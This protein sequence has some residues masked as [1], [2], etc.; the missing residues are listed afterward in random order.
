VSAGYVPATPSRLVEQGLSSDNVRERRAEYGYNEVKEAP[1]RPL[2]EFLKRLW[3][4]VPWMLEVA[5]ALELVLGKLP[6]TLI[7]AGLLVFNAILGEVQELRAQ[8]ALD[9]LR[10]RLHVTARVRRDASWAS[11]PA[12]ELV[13]GDWIHVRMGDIVPADC[14]LGEGTVE[15]DQSALTGESTPVARSE[16]ETI[17]SGSTVRRGEASGTVTATGP[18]SFFGR[19][20]E[21]VRTAR[22][23]GHLE[24]LL[25]NIVR[26]LVTIDAVLAGTVLAAALI[27]GAPLL[28]LLPFVLVLLIA[29]VP[30]AMPATFT[31]A[32]AIEAR[33]LADEGVLVTGLSA[34]QEAATMEML[35]VDKTGTLTQN[36]AVLEGVRS[37]AGISDDELVAW[38]A[39]ACDESTQDPINLAILEAMR[40]RKMRAFPR[41]KFLPFDPANKRSEGEVLRD[42]HAYRVVLGS[43]LVVEKLARAP[44][45][46]PTAVDRLAGS[47]ARV[48]AVAVGV[49]DNLEVRGLVALA[50]PPREDAAALVQSL[51]ALGIRVIMLTGDTLP[52]ARAVA[53]EVG[54]GDHIGDRVAAT[55]DPQRYDG[56][57]GVYPE[58]KFDLVKTLQRSGEVV[59]MTGDGV[60]DA[61]ALKQAEVGIAVA[62]A[63]DVAKASAKLVLTRPGLRD[64][65]SAVVGG[66]RVYRR[67][68]T[69]TITKISK[70]LEFVLLLS[71]VFLATGDLAATPFLIIL[72]IFSNDFVTITVGAD[73]ARVSSEPDRWNVREIATV[74][75]VLGSAWLALSLTVF[76][77]GLTVLGLSLAQ[78]QTLVFLYLVFSSQATVYL[79]RVR[80]PFWS[81]GPSPYLVVATVGAGSFV[82]VLAITGTLMARI[83]IL[84][85]A[86]VLGIVAVAAL[87]IDRAKI[88]VFRW[89]GLLGEVHP[90]PVAV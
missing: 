35:C 13:P 84:L 23:T 85:V 14:V 32:N 8:T 20:A 28:P 36:R 50:D 11:V 42:G 76:W 10:T 29:S 60:N 41:T 77:L 6:E 26:Y 90:R 52:T 38:A 55:E 69:W 61:P 71:I 21:L 4:P 79:A 57:A 17:Y 54:I 83:P 19:T 49:G 25:F 15:V 81:F 1:R 24:Q 9:L 7:I 27:R 12:R 51:H 33:E 3:G 43:P 62:S 78:V 82:S 75:A 72:L 58:D 16:R 53:R 59:G 56:F 64:I 47:G 70:N 37:L 44:E 86:E 80:G 74:A 63:T 68:L 34:I 30:V 67:M 89:T 2:R 31:V 22:S 66:R 45:G 39:A 73:R 88:W 46:L 5:L 18:R 48:L 87:A 65:V 40:A